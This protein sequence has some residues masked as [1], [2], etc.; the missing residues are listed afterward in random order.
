MID[1]KKI[2]QLL[3]REQTSEQ[4]EYPKHLILNLYPVLTTEEKKKEDYEKF[5]SLLDSVLDLQIEKKI[6]V[7]TIS[8]GKKEHILNENMLSNFCEKLL[9]KAN[10]KKINVTIFGRWYDLGGELVESLKKLNN[11]TNDFDNFFFNLCI[12]YDGKQEISDACRVIIKKI[13]TQ[14]EKEDL[15]TPELIKENIYCSYFIP[16][17]LIIESTNRFKGT[18][19]WDSENARILFL[20]KEVIKIT[21]EDIERVIDLYAKKE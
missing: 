10:N 19:L 11:E 4:K 1:L 12:N 15:I 6:P 7:F 17:D 2:Q 13:L 18:F 20:N 16:A 8:L 3:Q 5:L 14:K 21:K 9:E